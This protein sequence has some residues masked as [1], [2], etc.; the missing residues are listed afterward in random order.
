MIFQ[1][2]NFGNLISGG[3]TELLGFFPHYLSSFHQC[4]ESNYILPSFLTRE[5]DIGFIDLAGVLELERGVG[6]VLG[7]LRITGSCC[8]VCFL[9]SLKSIHSEHHIHPRILPLQYL[10]SPHNLS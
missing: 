4:D 9:L 10:F 8:M 7:I 2:L 1:N 5:L 6:D 3:S